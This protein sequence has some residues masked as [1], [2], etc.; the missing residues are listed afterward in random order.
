MVPKE[1]T[2]KTLILA[3]ANSPLKSMLFLQN[4]GSTIPSKSGVRGGGGMDKG[5][6]IA[7]SLEGKKKKESLFYT[8]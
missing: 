3:L 4:L 7:K 5:V 8:S 2:S 1:G 6:L